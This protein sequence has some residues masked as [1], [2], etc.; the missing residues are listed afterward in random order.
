MTVVVWDG[1]CIAADKLIVLG[2]RVLAHIPKIKRLDDGRLFG[3]CGTTVHMNLMYDWVNEG[4]IEYPKD[5]GDDAGFAFFV[6]NLNK[7][8]LFYDSICPYPME[9]GKG[10][11]CIG[12]GADIAQGLVNSG[13]DAV[14]CVKETSKVSVY[15]GGGVNSLR[16][17]ALKK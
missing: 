5:M 17:L 12:S 8:V 13:V 10:K 15:C 9:L 2:E 1:V 11:F 7:T 3:F 6:V 14:K 4:G 16:L